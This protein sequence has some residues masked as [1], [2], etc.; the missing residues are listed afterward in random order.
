MTWFWLILAEGVLIVGLVLL[1]MRDFLW[2]AGQRR[3]AVS[4]GAPPAV[5]RPGTVVGG[6]NSRFVRTRPGR[7]LAR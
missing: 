5:L 2:T 4:G 7:W 1:A 3:R 6:L